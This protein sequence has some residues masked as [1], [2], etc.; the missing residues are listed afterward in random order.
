M[1][2][3]NTMD[4]WVFSFITGALLSLSWPALPP[5]F[6]LPIICSLTVI[7]L[8]LFH[9][10]VVSG[11]LFGTLWMA[12]VGHWTLNWQLPLSQ[13]SDIQQISGV[14]KNIV[15]KKDDVRLLVDADS[16]YLG[17]RKVTS[18]FG[19]KIRLNWKRPTWQV[20]QGQTVKLSVRLKPAH[21][22][23]NQGAFH[24]QTW[25]FSQNIMATGYV[26]D[27]SAELVNE[28][29]GVRQKLY[30]Q[31]MGIQLSHPEW[32][33]AL[34]MGERSGLDDKQW[35]LIQ[36]T[37]IA[38]L[39]AISG[40]HLS[41]VAVVS[42]FVFNLVLR[43]LAKFFPV[44]QSFNLVGTVCLC[45][46]VT[47]LLYAWIA[48]FAIPV[49]RAWCM[50]LAISY[51]V[52]ARR[53]WRISSFCLYCVFCFIVVFPRSLFTSSFWLSF[54]AVLF[55]CFILWRWPD[56]KT[57]PSFTTR[58]TQLLKLQLLLSI[59]MLPIVGGQFSYTS[60][61][62]PLVNLLAVPSVTLII[63]P[64]CL[65]GVLCLMLN[66]TLPATLA[67]QLVDGCL[68]LGLYL[69]SMTASIDHS[70]H[71]FQSMPLMV[72]GLLLLAILLLCLPVE[73]RHRILALVIALPFGTYLVLARQ[74]GWEIDVLDVGQGTSVLLTRNN[75]GI[76]F[77]TGPA[78][79]SGYNT[80]SA[81]IMPVLAAKGI[82]QLD[83][84]VIS[85]HDNDHAGS[86]P[87]LLENVAVKGVISNLHGC[88][89]ELNL[90]WQGLRLEGLWPEKQSEVSSNHNSCVVRVSDGKNRVLITGDI[91]KAAELSLVGLFPDSLAADVMIAPHH[92]SKT[93][94][95]EGFIQAVAPSFVVFTVGFMNQWGFPRQE[96]V[97]RYY[98]AE[99]HMYSTA[100]SGL[101]RFSFG[102]SEGISVRTFRQDMHNLW[103]ANY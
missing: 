99:T 58:C 29:S 25:L 42:A 72:W 51:L 1:E 27:P 52:V 65:V 46:L 76:L 88:D 86:L 100:D 95:T 66:L 28:Q 15:T 93:S 71:D 11:F 21:G 57:E 39:I 74:P 68:E 101:I 36:S 91:D 8:C 59:L 70:Q 4:R 14:V 53:N 48:G 62:S 69:L 79:P 89:Q 94:S 23:A 35:H 87:T 3:R 103:Y 6:L 49:V 98:L 83:L 96:V 63:V 16:L 60:L 64:L 41:S 40:L 90:Y 77:D 80:A 54:G 73:N 81:V 10:H 38:H 2:L 24:Y 50:L 7:F 30:D 102:K 12:S 19:W 97:N 32:I 82:K 67:F 85:H 37:G 84:V 26:S 13:I 43:A 22:L 5:P 55:I 47:C 17:K 44:S 45:S 61:V 75:R 9:M 31:L 78:Y 56:R 18:A 20:K 92:G 33:A 34:A